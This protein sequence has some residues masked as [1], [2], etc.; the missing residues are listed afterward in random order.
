MFVDHFVIVLAL[1]IC[2]FSVA[3]PL[4]L[5]P[6]VPPTLI[7]RQLP[8][9]KMQMLADTEREH[10]E[11]AKGGEW[12][13]R[14]CIAQQK[15]AIMIPYRNRVEHLRGLLANL[16]PFLQRQQAHFRIFVVEQALPVG[17]RVDKFNK[18]KLINAGFVEI[19]NSGKWDC[20]ILHDVDLVPEHDH[21]LYR[22]F[23]D[24]PTHFFRRF[25]ENNYAPLPDNNFGEVS[26][27]TPEQYQR[28]NGYS[29]LFWGWG[30][31]DVDMF[32]RILSVGYPDER[33]RE[34]SA[35]ELGFYTSLELAKGVN[36]TTNTI[37]NEECRQR[38]LD[39]AVKR[40]PLDGLN[41]I[42]GT[43]K[44]VSVQENKLFTNIAIDLLM[45]ESRKRADDPCKDLPDRAKIVE[46]TLCTTPMCISR[47]RR[48][49]KK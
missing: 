20:I 18:A 26:G 41:T 35:P 24:H 19:T 44:V 27:F 16:I 14:T 21:N 46:K 13:P 39:S 47:R 1:L 36:D 45:E 17:K 4:P 11:I 12:K 6:E 15:V 30:D 31:E 40:M 43:Y 5:C 9:K 49:A 34:L 3:E 23:K 48:N 37:G 8:D 42:K 29:N 10:P 7:G 28:V 2:P 38:L 22:C 25:D 33:K 32:N